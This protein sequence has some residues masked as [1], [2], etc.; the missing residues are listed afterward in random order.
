MAH[1]LARQPPDGLGGNVRDRGR[2]LRCIGLHVLDE[3]GEGRLH[4]LAHTAPRPVGPDLNTGGDVLALHRRAQAVGVVEGNRAVLAG[5]PDERL[6]G[7]RVTQVVPAGADE[8]GR[9]GHALEERDVA[10]GAPVVLQQDRVEQGE[11]HGRVRLRADRHPLGRPGARHGQMG[12]ELDPVEAAGPRLGV[13]EHAGDPAGR[14]TV[15]AEGQDEVT[16]RQIRRHRERTVPE[17]AVEVLGVIALDALAAADALIHRPPGGQEGGEGAE[18]GGGDAA[19][20]QGHRQPRIAGLVHEPLGAEGIEPGRQGAERLLPG[21]GLPAGILIT[22]LARVGAPHRRLDARGVVELL[23]QCVGAHAHG[24]AG[25]VD[26]GHLVVGLDADG[27]AVLDHDPEQVRSRDA[28]V[29]VHRDLL[30]PAV[31]GHATRASHIRSPRLR[32]RLAQQ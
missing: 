26:V 1:V 6:L 3:A 14:V 5:I 27:H 24:S 15:V 29:A 22:A 31:G 16:A 18:V 2:P 7:L 19:R 30:Q 11:E 8:V 17:L 12:L 20:A 9:A 28:L 23:D 10:H 13:P 25:R 32:R 21:D 4:P